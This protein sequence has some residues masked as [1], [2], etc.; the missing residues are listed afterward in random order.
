MITTKSNE[1]TDVSKLQTPPS[2]R[3]INGSPSVSVVANSP[4]ACDTPGASKFVNQDEVSPEEKTDA[5]V[6]V[7]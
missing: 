7:S 5:V 1:V 4:S 2:S 3:S 6:K